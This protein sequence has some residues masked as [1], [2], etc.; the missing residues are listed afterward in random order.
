MFKGVIN[1]LPGQE[2]RTFSVSRPETRGTEN[3]REGIT[4]S[5]VKLGELRAI[6]AQAK[7]EEVQRWSML[8][9]PI[10][11][12]II[13]KGK[14]PFEIKPGYIFER[15]GRRFYHEM[16]PYDP[17]DLGHWTIFYCGERKDVK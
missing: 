2:L 4:N 16:T 15:N 8:N 12:K 7:P 3:G 1:L 11:H 9:H 6:L 10:T 14:P 13:M 5:F 17:G